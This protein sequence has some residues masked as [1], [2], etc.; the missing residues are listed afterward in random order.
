MKKIFR[1]AIVCALAGAALLTGC[2]KDYGTDIANLQTEINNLKTDIGKLQDAINAGCVI[3]GVKQIAD[4]YEIS[5]SDGQK[6]T[7]KNGAKGDKGDTGAKGDKGDTGA[8]GDKG[9][10]GANGKSA[11]DL[12][13]EGGYTGTLEEWLESLKGAKGED[14]KSAYDLAVEKGYEGTIEDWI[15]SLQ[16]ENGKSAYELAVE[17]GYEGTLEEWIASLSPIV[18]IEDVEGVPYW[19]INGEKTEYV[20]KGDKGDKGED[21]N[22]W[23]YDVDKFQWVEYKLVDGEETAT[24]VREDIF[25]NGYRPITAF[26][27]ED[28]L[29]FSNVVEGY[30]EDGNAIFKEGG[31][32]LDLRATL[33]SI[34][35]IPDLYYGGI[36]AF[37]YYYLEYL[38]GGVIQNNYETV[39]EL[40]NEAQIFLKDTLVAKNPKNFFAGSHSIAHY[41]IN[42]ERYELKNAEWDLYPDDKVYMPVFG[43]KHTGWV[44]NF[45]SAVRDEDN[46]KIVKVEYTIDN[47]DCL[48][49]DIDKYEAYMEE[50]EAAAGE[51]TATT[52]GAGAAKKECDV[53]VS[54]MHL[55]GID[56]INE[57]KIVASDF[58][59][60]IPMKQ[61]IAALAFTKNYPADAEKCDVNYDHLWLSAH[62]A[63]ENIPSVSVYYNGGDFPL[64][65]VGVHML[66]ADESMPRTTGDKHILKTLAELQETYP[67][68][69]M[70]FEFVSCK[71]G[72]YE[73]VEE[74]FGKIKIKEGKYYF[75]PCYADAAGNPVEIASLP[76]D[77]RKDVGAS[78][79]GRRP[80]I[81][82]KLIDKENSN[83]IVL[84][85]YFKIHIDREGVTPEPEGDATFDGII[86]KDFS[87][88]P[89]TFDCAE[90]SLQTVWTDFSEPVLENFLNIEYDEWIKNYTWLKGSHGGN[91]YATYTYEQD[92][93]KPVDTYDST[94]GYNKYGTIEY[95]NDTGASAINDV[96]KVTVD[97]RQKQNIVD[98]GGVVTLWAM[99]QKNGTKEYYLFG[100]TIKVNDH[101]DASFILHN[102]NYW[103]PE[104]NDVYGDKN[105]TVRRNVLV[106]NVWLSENAPA[107]NDSVQ[108]YEKYLTD[109]W[110]GNIIQIK[111]GSKTYTPR[112]K[113]HNLI[114]TYKDNV[115]YKFQFSVKSE[116]PFIDGKQ[117]VVGEN[118]D[119]LYY[120]GDPV[121]ALNDTSGLVTY[122]WKEDSLYISKVLL[123]KWAPY[124]EKIEEIL[125]C[126]V[127]LIAYSYEEAE[128]EGEEDCYI[129]L[130]KEMIHVRFLRPLTIK[131][132]GDGKLRDAVPTGDAIYL[133][134]LFTA[135]DW[136]RQI[137]PEGFLIF[138]KYYDEEKDSTWFETCY[139]PDRY[140]KETAKVEWYGYYGFSSLSIDMD[141]IE[142]NQNGSWALIK[143]VN[144]AAKFWLAPADDHMDQT[145][146]GSGSVDIS[147]LSDLSNIV[148]VY[149]NNIGVVENFALRIPVSITYAWGV[150]TDMVE[151]P[152]EGTKYHPELL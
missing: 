87:G 72:I 22:Y 61:G 24:G 10:T 44:P 25:P 146:Y 34:V 127:D 6:Y 43:T 79:I 19:F 18:T 90:S 31:Y 71:L 20:A 122:I 141:K 70:T 94:L 135:R 9:D 92:G 81:L 1:M 52:P 77:L 111:S 96:F 16:G 100:V 115:F 125:Y 30:D 42:P 73:T 144:P 65:F 148:F 145:T 102:S 7:I 45:I 123:N 53:D 41:F 95:L 68:F 84:A 103:W 21:G 108:I 15:A 64:D 139:Y 62:E 63:V 2:T 117:W 36:E 118:R 82:V 60:V 39:D 50:M 152:V 27:T 32:V 150:Y 88:K 128:V 133:G 56:S 67:N 54:I 12:A 51:V 114:A 78:A 26:W 105:Q 138:D 47:A 113:D 136:N 69:D 107:D 147:D 59:A 66:D 101:A 35:S 91:N 76:E 142:S 40:G 38:A 99:F 55:E 109:D 120:N 130:G 11:Y 46:P 98:A 23:K 74:A 129:E 4:G 29:A 126:N 49:P 3:T 75:A 48:E 58:A 13:K 17:N 112:D 151:V 116:Q 121:V 14:G 57:N 124:S 37:K 143:N 119:T 106:P 140:N 80:V 85:G 110:V 5:T 134:E 86:V 28:G 89:F 33:K 93:K 131:Y 8:K 149:F 137:D 83:A 97:W 104:L 132:G